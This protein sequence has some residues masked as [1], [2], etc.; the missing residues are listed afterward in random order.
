MLDVYIQQD[1]V[2]N[3]I[4]TAELLFFEPHSDLAS[5]RILRKY[6]PED[7]WA[8]KST[9]YRRKLEKYYDYGALA[10]VLNEENMPEELLRILTVSNN[11]TL[12]QKYEPHIPQQ[13]KSQLQKIYFSLITSSLALKADR[14]SYRFNA[15]LLKSMLGKYD[16]A[17]IIEFA[18]GLRDQ[19]KQRKALIDE[20][21]V[22]PKAL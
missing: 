4:S 3:V 18:N 8:I 15:R 17:A 5:Y 12:V 14:A 13:F 10:E 19:Y 20:L 22:I 2:Q 9:E 6:I 11:V 21:V 1:D 7:Q 16:D